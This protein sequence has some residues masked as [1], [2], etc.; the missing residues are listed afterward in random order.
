MLMTT[1]HLTGKLGILQRPYILTMRVILVMMNKL[2]FF[3][4]ENRN[5]VISDR[6]ERFEKSV[7]TFKRTL[8]NF[9]DSKNYLF[10]LVIYGLMFQK[11]QSYY[12][13]VNT[14]Q[15]KE[16]AQEVLGDD[17]HFDLVEI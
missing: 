7:E 9:P 6:F 5:E 3:A 15:D 8:N 13:L 10:N 4:P 1:L 14:R 17:L 2:S 11:Q 16:K 12:Q